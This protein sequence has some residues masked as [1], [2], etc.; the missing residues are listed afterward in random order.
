MSDIKQ[1]YLNIIMWLLIQL[2]DENSPCPD[3][4]VFDLTKQAQGT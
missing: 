1:S 2:F 4:Q 3:D